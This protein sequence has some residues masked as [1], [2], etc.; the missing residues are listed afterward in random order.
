[1]NYRDGFTFVHVAEEKIGVGYRYFKKYSG[2]TIKDNKKKKFSCKMYVRDLKLNLVTKIHKN[3]D[4]I[5][6]KKKNII[7]K[8]FFETNFSVIQIKEAY[9]IMI[10]DLKKDKKIVYTQKN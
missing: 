2:I 8:N 1:M 6:E 7:S 5:L 3:L 4:K 10:R 9:N